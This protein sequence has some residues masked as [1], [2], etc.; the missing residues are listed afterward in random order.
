M[1]RDGR[2][3]ALAL[4]LA[5]GCGGARPPAP[6][7]P[8]ARL[9]EGDLEPYAVRGVMSEVADRRVPRVT[10]P[11]GW[12]GAVLGVGLAALADVA[13]DARYVG[14]L[15]ALGESAAYR[16][17]RADAAVGALAFLALYQ[18]E[19][20]P[21]Q[22][23]PSV[24]LFDELTDTE[25]DD[26]GLESF[27]EPGSAPAVAVLMA[28]AAMALATTVTG[29]P[30]YLPVAERLWTRLGERLADP[31][32]HLFHDPASRDEPLRITGWALVALA[33]TL[34]NLP[35]QDP[36]RAR[37]ET[38]F[39]DSATALSRA[40]RSD[41]AWRSSGAQ[42]DP[43][44]TALAVHA[45]AWGMNHGL[46]PRSAFEPARRA[47]RV[48][49]Q[50]LG[51]GPGAAP[52]AVALDADGAAAVLLGGAELFKLVLFQGSREAVITAANPLGEP[53]FEETA[54]IVWPP[55]ARTLGA[56]PGDPIVAVDELSGRILPSQL[57]SADGSPAGEQLLV[58][59][60]L[61]GNESRRVVVRRLA[62]PFRPARPLARAYG[63]FV[64]E[65]RD[66]FAWENDRVAFRVYGPALEQA[67]VSSGIDVWA[68]RVR[69]PVIDRWYGQGSYRRD[70]GE[71]LD[72][73]SVGPSRGCGGLGLW[74]GQTLFT[75]RNF[76]RW[77]VVATG[78][79]RVAF[80]LGYD[81][82]GPE[83]AQVTETKRI[84]LDLGQNLS[85]I[86]SRFSV[87]GGPRTLPVAVGIVRRGEG[88]LA[89]DLPTTW[90]SYVEPP[91]GTS[92][93]IGCGVVGP[94]RTRFHESAEHY[95]LVRDHPSD[96]P[97]V[98]Y[99][100]AY[101]SKAPDFTDPDDWSLYLAAFSRREDAPI[102]VAAAP[103]A[104][105]SRAT[106]PTAGQAAGR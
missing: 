11:L 52:G 21:H 7:T 90:L 34:E 35:D 44:T 62:R 54:E 85:R 45:L 28:P 83:G 56:V 19:R 6:A 71:G 79:V 41:G 67:Q 42:L 72:F 17:V 75:S 51:G 78:P 70:S 99:A 84:S 68:K 13:E 50:A 26:P 80:E 76:H 29:D 4:L 87:Q 57:F 33:R 23:A 65:R 96:R 12:R 100:G 93:Q 94:A 30:R 24:A 59:M 37:Y 39:R 22:I 61:L 88:R 20:D 40:Q 36:A 60:S 63:R 3:W 66:D 16:P 69:V 2:C 18:R 1:D 46:L 8:A 82:W 43:A 53:R 55:L 25:S 95:L 31:A 14:A 49:A 102:A 92:G 86:E 103:L 106:P 74:D 98:Y 77:R 27:A 105:G 97:F 58:S 32:T 73:Y 10:A 38:M 5:L 47:W 81:P 89:R 48:L 64:P 91:Q 15:R 101:W 9:D 104:E